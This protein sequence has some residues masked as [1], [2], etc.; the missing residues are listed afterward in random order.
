[1]GERKARL[2]QVLF[3]A[4]AILAPTAVGGYFGRMAGGFYSQHTVW[5]R[6]GMAWGL[7]GGFAAGCLWLLAMK[8]LAPLYLPGRTVL[9]GTILGTISGVLVTV[10]VHTG[11]TGWDVMSLPL[12]IGVLF[13]GI[14]AGFVTGLVCGIGTGA[15]PHGTETISD[16][17]VIFVLVGGAFIGGG[18]GLL[19]ALPDAFYSFHMHSHWLNGDAGR[20]VIGIAFGAG[21][22]VVAA[23]LWLLA[24]WRVARNADGGKIMLCGIALGCGAG[25]WAGM[26]MQLGL[27]AMAHSDPFGPLV[28][29]LVFGTVAGF[30]TGTACGFALWWLRGE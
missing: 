30:T 23:I 20:E 5:L 26:L 14:P 17:L 18:F 12:Q 1:M 10:L 8:Y 13:Y 21:S 19:A 25:T 16:K 22:G 9:A 24:M 7:G 15:W 3:T 6:A 4:F 11:L 27:S 29:G 28:A 2:P